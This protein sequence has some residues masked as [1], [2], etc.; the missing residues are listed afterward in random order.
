[1]FVQLLDT[2]ER[3]KAFVISKNFGEQDLVSLSLNYPFQYKSYSLIT[4]ATANYK[5]LS[6]GFGNDRNINLN[7]T[8]FAFLA[9]NSI[10]FKETW[11][12]E[13]TG[14][15]NSPTIY[16]SNLRSKTM[17]SVDAGIQ[18]QL[19]GGKANLKF[20]VSDVFNSLQ[21]EGQAFFA[22]QETRFSR[23]AE[24]RQAKISLSWRFGSNTIKE[25]R[26]N[27][28]AAEDEMKRVQ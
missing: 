14:F 26:Q 11:T 22:G 18:K 16:G 6:A 10:K 5:K 4:N 21:F 27:K 23:K 24:S 1:M 28:V 13:L 17:W 19:F 20:A 7:A 25:A 3:S 15:Y 8:S 9:Q 2:V 12:A